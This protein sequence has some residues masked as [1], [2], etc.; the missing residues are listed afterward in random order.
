VSGI[1]A[2]FNAYKKRVIADGGFVEGENCAIDKLKNPLLNSA[3]LV[4]IP[5]GVKAT[6]VY[7]ERPTNGSGDFTFARASTATRT[8]ASGAIVSV[9]SNVP[10][11]DY[12]TAAGTLA[13]CPMLEVEG[14]RTNLLLQ[15]NTFNTTWAF[16][17]TGTVTQGATDPFGGTTA[18]TLAKTA[19]NTFIFQGTT[20]FSGSSTFS[21]YAKA[22]T[23][24]QI[25]LLH[26]Q[27]VQFNAFFDL[28]LGTIV[29]ST[30]CVAT[31]VSVGGGWYRCSIAGTVAGATNIRIYPASGGS[32][33]GTTGNILIYAAQGEL[34]TFSSTVIPTTTAT[35]TRILDS[36]SISG[37]SALIGQTE[38]TI[39]LDVDFRAVSLGGARC[40]FGI[41][42]SVPSAFRGFSVTTTNNGNDVQGAGTIYAITQ[43]R[44]KIVLRYNSTTNVS[45]LFVDGAQRGA[46][47]SAAFASTIDR[48]SV[49]GRI[50]PFSSFAV[51][52]QQFG[53]CNQFAVWKTA[54]T[55]AQCIQLSTL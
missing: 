10:R 7:S 27:T 31:I 25:Y 34:G 43:G 20:A 28:T 29:S 37:A 22:G 19:A 48:I 15:S 36:V 30:N 11:L 23:V 45:K 53:G 40:F 18:W 6:K 54:L 17:G 4:L 51:D 33:T 2:F 41:E 46:S 50:N 32:L 13:I 47:T 21:I 49:L 55:D 14:Q 8:N 24:D 42:G 52:R 12:M 44:H 16:S 1:R 3:S 39:F 9:A 35:V 38:G 5:S 26:T